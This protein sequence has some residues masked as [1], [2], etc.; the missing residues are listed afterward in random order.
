MCFIIFSFFHYLLPD[1]KST[2][3]EPK[4]KKY[5]YSEEEKKIV[6]EIV[7]N[8]ANGQYVKVIKD[9]S[10]TLN[11]LKNRYRF[12][13]FVLLLIYLFHQGLERYHRPL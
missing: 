1:S 13:S 11:N 7:N 5:I 2:M 10:T 6:M 12:V 3:T 4:G 8:G 9:K